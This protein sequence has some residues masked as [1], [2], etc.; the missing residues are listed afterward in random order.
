MA[1][2]TGTV[3]W[4]ANRLDQVLTDLNM[5]REEFMDCLSAADTYPEAL[6]NLELKALEN[7]G[8]VSAAWSG[9]ALAA[10]AGWTSRIGLGQAPGMEK[11]PR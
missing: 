6:G 2:E 8:S 1:T 4:I 10:L 7:G 5:T 3:Q 9:M 11:R